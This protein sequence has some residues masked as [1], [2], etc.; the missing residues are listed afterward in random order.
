LP[1]IGIERPSVVARVPRRSE[2]V[3]CAA[4]F[5]VLTVV[6]LPTT[7]RGDPPLAADEVRD[8]R[9]MRE[10]RPLWREALALPNEA[11]LLVAWPL[12][13]FLC[14]AEDVRLA[15]RVRDVAL[16]PIEPQDSEDP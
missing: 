10:E 9:L 2:R 5:A 4:L 7:A 3:L 14:W 13:Q 15:T 8:R 11:L 6:G 16:A 12:R 1:G